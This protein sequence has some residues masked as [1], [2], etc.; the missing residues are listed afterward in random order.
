MLD[1][2][3]DHLSYFILVVLRDLRIV[4]IH[5]LSLR[6][7]ST[8]FFFRGKM[9]VRWNGDFLS[10]I[11]L[12]V[13]VLIVIPSHVGTKSLGTLFET[14]KLGGSM[15]FLLRLEQTPAMFHRLFKALLAFFLKPHRSSIIHYRWRKQGTPCLSR[16][17]PCSFY[18]T[19][20]GLHIQI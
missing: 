1:L 8:F 19:S 16:S 2:F 5:L 15:L 4:K 14:A 11:D 18:S 9:C 10:V 3:R 17:Q 12:V 6:T 20:L 13:N 7:L